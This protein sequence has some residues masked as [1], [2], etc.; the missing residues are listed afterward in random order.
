VIRGPGLISLPLEYC[1]AR[2]WHWVGAHHGYRH[3]RALSSARR[4]PRALLHRSQ[5]HLVR[6]ADSGSGV[7]RTLLDAPLSSV[8]AVAPCRSRGPRGRQRAAIQARELP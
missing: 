1:G 4:P 5:V 2:F 6:V 8:N 7:G 3:R